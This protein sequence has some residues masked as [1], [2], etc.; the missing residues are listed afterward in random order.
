[1]PTT[2]GIDHGAEFRRCLLQCDVAGLMA[3]H[4]HIAPWDDKLTPEHALISL[5]MARVEVQNFPFKVRNYSR[6]WLLDHGYEKV[7]GQWRRTEAKER[8]AFVEAVGIASGAFP[9][10]LKG[11]FNYLVERVQSDAVL[12]ALAKGHHEPQ[13]HSEVMAKARARVRFKARKD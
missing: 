5:H 7:N 1:M 2:P 11:P 8:Q 4:K 6:Q 13:M 12:N 10:N 3:V 9:G